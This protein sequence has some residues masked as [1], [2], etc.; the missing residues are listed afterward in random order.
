MSVTTTGAERSRRADATA[1]ARSPEARPL[2][3]GARA[4]RRLGWLLCAPAVVIMVAVAAY[5]II[6]SV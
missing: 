5:P 1:A 6:Y 2:S 4:E 3:E